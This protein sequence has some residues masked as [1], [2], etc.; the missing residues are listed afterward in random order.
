[1]TRSARI[2]RIGFL[3]GAQVCASCIPCQEQIGR[4]PPSRGRSPSTI[5][6][7][8]CDWI[9]G[10]RTMWL[11][12]SSKSAPATLR[13]TLYGSFGRS[14]S[15]WYRSRPLHNRKCT[16]ELLDL[17]CRP[18]CHRCISVDSSKNSLRQRK[19]LLPSQSHT[20]YQW[21]RQRL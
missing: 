14:C 3:I 8:T 19:P 1:M 7:L 6:E 10:G 5:C 21:R 9:W 17:T 11:H 4:A 20:L 15:P 2:G 16:S 18:R 12:S 13:V